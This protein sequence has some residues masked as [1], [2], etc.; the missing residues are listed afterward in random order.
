MGACFHCKWTH[1]QDVREMGRC[2]CTCHVANHRNFRPRGT[3]RTLPRDNEPAFWS[4][5]ATT[6]ERNQP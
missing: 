3:R 4:D 1:N 6:D 2:W 5:P